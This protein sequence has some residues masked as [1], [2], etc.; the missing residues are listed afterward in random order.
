[1]AVPQ[2][3]KREYDRRKLSVDV[4]GK[5]RSGA[6][7][8]SFASVSAEEKPDTFFG[9]GDV[10]DLTVTVHSDDI[11]DDK[12]LNFLCSGGTAGATYTVSLRYASSDETHLESI[13]EVKV[14]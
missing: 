13:I 11:T 4:S 10:D 8:D 9:E 7:V 3:T 6:T 1:M 5:L 14:V 2:L 12:I